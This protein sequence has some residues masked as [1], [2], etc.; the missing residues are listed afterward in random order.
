MIDIMQQSKPFEHQL[1]RQ[2]YSFP[3]TS[4]SPIDNLQVALLDSW[5]T[6]HKRNPFAEESGDD[7][8]DED[9]GDHYEISEEDDQCHWTW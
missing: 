9:R 4:K 7:E 6:N 1:G 5:W 3:H 2:L 8:E